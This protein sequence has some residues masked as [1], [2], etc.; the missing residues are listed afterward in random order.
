MT[1]ICLSSISITTAQTPAKKITG[2]IYRKPVKG[3]YYYQ[4]INNL[5][6]KD[7]QYFPVLKD[8][9]L[10]IFNIVIDADAVTPPKGFDVNP[11]FTAFQNDG[12]KVLQ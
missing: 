2:K 1:G 5:Q 10:Q 9:L 12:S 11:S 4:M 7:K 8:K 3:K 6:G